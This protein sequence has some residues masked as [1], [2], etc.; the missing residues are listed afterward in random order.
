[1]LGN[2]LV[3]EKMWDFY[4]YMCVLMILCMYRCT[5]VFVSFLYV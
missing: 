4:V 2:W 5:C 1:M 3:A